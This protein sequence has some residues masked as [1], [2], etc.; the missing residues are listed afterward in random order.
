M[1]PKQSKY[2][3]MQKM[4]WLFDFWRGLSRLFKRGLTE[5]TFWW[6]LSRLFWWGLSRLF[7]TTTGQTFL[8]R[9][10]QT[11][12]NIQRR[13]LSNCCD[14]GDDKVTS[15]KPIGFC[16]WF[17][18]A[19]LKKSSCKH[20]LHALPKQLRRPHLRYLQSASLK[21]DDSSESAITS[22]IT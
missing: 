1:C 16:F 15:Q 2:V 14:N 19:T 6:G 20:I 5:Q 11:F 3:F 22:V 4:E 7:L 13:S 8:V 9:T 21:F 12:D 10:E 17:P 18:M